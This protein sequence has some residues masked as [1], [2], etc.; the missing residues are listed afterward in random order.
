[1]TP[2]QDSVRS[3]QSR[4][5]RALLFGL[6]AR[7]MGFGLLVGGCAL[8]IGR[9]FGFRW[10]V[11]AA[12]AGV[13]GG[14]VWAIWRFRQ[15]RVNEQ[16][17]LTL[18]DLRAGGSGE[19][20]HA[21]ET[22]GESGGKLNLASTRPRPAWRSSVA[23]TLVPGVLFFL[24]GIL[25]PVRAMAQ[26]STDLFT[27]QRLN[28]LEELAKALDETLELE[29][30]LQEEIEQNIDTLRGSDEAPHPTGEA[31]REALDALERRLEE[32]AELAA[33]E[34]E[35]VIRQAGE[36]AQKGAQ[37]DPKEHKSALDALGDLF[38]QSQQNGLQP[39]NKLE[40]NL[41]EQLTEAGLSQE[42]LKALE[43]LAQAGR[44]PELGNLAQQM[45]LSPEEIAK[46][47]EALANNLSEAALKKLAEMAKRG[48]LDPTSGKPNMQPPDPE[49]L[50]EYLKN[51]EKLMEQQPGGT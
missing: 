38:Q 43:K 18:L 24:L 16:Q 17:M 50:A 47:A 13:I 8:L 40:I 4:W 45:G 48:L 9:G 42:T 46:L 3:G 15:L 34:L 20:L 6:T 29:E 26:P 10:E 32:T 22:G 28:E 23:P 44:M 5:N 31:M 35:E 12:I 19:L 21:F 33:S 14:L 49:K 37:P 41:M 2:L 1:M 11:P 25:V 51:L 7:G 27:E 36:A 39:E 30:E